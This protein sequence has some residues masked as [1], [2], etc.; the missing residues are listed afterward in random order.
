MTVP[1][2]Y[3]I[4]NTVSA[5]LQADCVAILGG[6]SIMTHTPEEAAETAA[7]CDALLIN[8][9]TPPYNAYDL[10]RT[11]LRAAADKAA[12]AVLDAVGSEYHLH[13]KAFVIQSYSRW[14]RGK[15]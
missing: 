7:S 12:P 10:Y 15:F 5:Q 8:T 14:R 4:T 11:A 13:L 1:L 3:Q 9:G 2:I 6:A